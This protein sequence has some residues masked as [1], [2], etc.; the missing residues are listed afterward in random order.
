MQNCRNRRKRG[1]VTPQ[2]LF[3]LLSSLFVSL[4]N[5][6]RRKY[7]Q[8]IGS[9]VVTAE[10]CERN[11]LF[12]SLLFSWFRPAKGFAIASRV[13]NL[14][15]TSPVAEAPAH[16]P[17]TRNVQRGT[18]NSQRSTTCPERA[19]DISP[20]QRPGTRPSPFSPTR[21]EGASDRRSAARGL[22]PARRT[23]RWATRTEALGVALS[24][25]GVYGWGRAPRAL[26]W[27]EE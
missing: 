19:Q 9:A 3:P 27:A 26:P 25:L 13:S 8:R 7:C 23:Q 14:T 15:A 18:Y 4:G 24:G 22:G 5:S 12:S 17:R 11:D 6:K 1:A 2:R 20:G 10:R 16:G 21:P